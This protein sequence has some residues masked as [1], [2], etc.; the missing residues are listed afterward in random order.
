MFAQKT[1]ALRLEAAVHRKAVL[2]RQ[3]GDISGICPDI[4]LQEKRREL[5]ISENTCLAV[6]AGCLPTTVLV[7]LSDYDPAIL[8]FLRPVFFADK[9]NRDLTE[10]LCTDI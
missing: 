4:P 9:D 1:S 3:Q 5:Q 10:L 2:R 6:P 7:T 8:I